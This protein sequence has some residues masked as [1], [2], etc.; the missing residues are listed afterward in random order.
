MRFFAQPP[1]SMFLHHHQRLGKLQTSWR[2]SDARRAR[3]S[4]SSIVAGNSSLRLFFLLIG[5]R[6]CSN[7]LRASAALEISSASGLS[8]SLSR[9]LKCSSAAALWIKCSLATLLSSY[10]WAART[11]TEIDEDGNATNRSRKT[12]QKAID[13]DDDRLIIPPSDRRLSDALAFLIAG[14]DVVPQRSR[15]GKW[16]ADFNSDGDIHPDRWPM[17][18]PVV[19]W[20]FG[21]PFTAVYRDYYA[22]VGSRLRKYIWLVTK[23]TSGDAL[24]H[25]GFHFGEIVAPRDK[26]PAVIDQK[27]TLHINAENYDWTHFKEIPSI[28]CVS[29]DLTEAEGHSLQREP[30]TA[31]D[32]Q[33]RTNIEV[34]N[35]RDDKIVKALIVE[36]KAPRSATATMTQWKKQMITIIAIFMAWQPL[37]VK[38]VSSNCLQGLRS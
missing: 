31:E 11:T 17:G 16:P 27:T 18:A 1:V 33:A 24:R 26:L 10:T 15:Y 34:T 36:R 6:R 19:V 22:M 30:Y 35:I 4:C 20:A 7:G 28:C 3:G 23:K 9:R 12:V 8:S 38:P 21:L 5:L 25:I 2:R 37:G 32:T 29:Q 14:H 13:P